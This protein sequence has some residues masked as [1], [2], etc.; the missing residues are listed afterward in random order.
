[1]FKILFQGDS[2]T[3]GNRYREPEKR[4]DLNHQT[5]HSYVYPIKARLMAENPLKYDIVN[6]GI[7]GNAV[8]DL[9][10]RWDV[11]A[12]D[13]NPDLL[14]I[15]IGINDSHRQVPDGLTLVQWY[16]SGYR[17]ILDRS[18]EKNPDLKLIILEPFTLRYASYKSETD[19][20]YKAR[21]ER[22]YGVQDAAK[23]I[24]SDYNAVFVELQQ[25]FDALVT[26]TVP[27]TY[28]IW[29]GLHPTEAGHWIVAEK[30]LSAAEPL[31]K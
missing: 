11:D 18:F 16:E 28:W 17:R 5:G 7:S 31:L 10:K 3:D 21:R 27:S 15:L 23:R 19:E 4:W 1:M 8:S 9:E 2:I 6:R 29:D 22:F 20:E 24:A 25:T 26:D 13:E 30:W 14:S 12:L